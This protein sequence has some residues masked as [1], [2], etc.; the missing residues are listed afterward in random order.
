MARGL[1]VLAALG[2]FPAAAWAIEIGQYVFAP[3]G[4][5]EDVRVL[6]VDG[7]G[8]KD[9]VFLLARSGEDGATREELLVLPTPATPVKGTFWT[10]QAARRVPLDEG[11][12]ARAGAIS[13]GRFGSGGAARVRFFDRQGVHDLAPS[14]EGTL[15]AVGAGLSTLFGRS[16]GRRI[17]FWDGH[18]DL[19]RD[20]VEECWFPTAEGSGQ[21]VL[22]GREE[23]AP[24]HLGLEVENRGATDAEHLFLR[25]AS[26]PGLA[27]ADVDGDGKRELVTVAGDTLLVFAADTGGEPKWRVPLPFVKTDLGPDEVHTPRIQLADVDG[28]GKTDLLVTL[29][30]GNR[31]DFTTFRTRLL[32]YPGPFVDP[33]TGRLVEPRVRIDTESVALH[34]TFVDLDGD[35]ALDY[36]NDSIRGGRF[37][38]IRRVLGAEP[39]IWYVGFRFDRARGTFETTPRFSVER[40]Y[41][42]EEAV[43]NH[44]GRSASFEG[45]FDGDGR[46]DLLDLG[47][48]KGL[49]IL[50]A[51]A[52]N[53][54]GPGDPISFTNRILPRVRMPSPLA[55]QLVVEDLTGDGLADAVVWSEDRIY[56]VSPRR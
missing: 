42:R 12:A 17:T 3:G 53:A 21:L 37:D 29:V 14:G 39:T 55:P 16:A 56:V 6:D 33:K 46:A 30:T 26:V 8:R 38:L 11:V 20:G 40:P 31:T 52:K 5:V 43:S 7:D 48:L 19:D 13:V 2:L 22:L 25:Y 54:E 1:I 49:E 36:V 51:V 34:P 41:S 24:R 50:G 23:A 27:P 35:G 45:D 32:H 4:R 44:F 9:L 10:A 28:D 15:Q 47:N 18:A